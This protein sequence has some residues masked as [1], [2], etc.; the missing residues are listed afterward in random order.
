MQLGQPALAT[1][2][3]Q[4]PVGRLYRG[5]FER[6]VLGV[7][8]SH[9]WRCCRREAVLTVDAAAGTPFNFDNFC[10][11]PE[12]FVRVVRVNDQIDKF[13]VIGKWI[14]VDDDA[15]ELTYIKRV[16]TGEFDDGLVMTIA[17]RCAASWCLS[18][19][20]ST[21][22]AEALRKEFESVFADAKFAD[23]LDGAPE[24]EPIGTWAEAR[25]SEA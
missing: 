14:A 17:A 18:I 8:R 11:L 20:E 24:D 16:P 19:T 25:L 10:A 7:L 4:S 15:P 13:E 3:E 12:G 23:A 2:L 22:R 21:T 6:I 9:P 1:G 5:T